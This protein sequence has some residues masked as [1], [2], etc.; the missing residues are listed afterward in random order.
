MFFRNR[1]PQTQVGLMVI[2][3]I[4]SSPT[5]TSGNLDPGQQ[6]I[7]RKYTTYGNGLQKENMPN[8]FP[9]SF[10]LVFMKQ[11]DV[12]REPEKPSDYRSIS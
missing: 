3:N 5:A 8:S 11:T 12:I 6:D 2:Q 4:P 9:S 7:R 1:I 10:L